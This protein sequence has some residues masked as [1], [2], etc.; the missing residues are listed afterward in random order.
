VN[1][2]GSTVALG[3]FTPDNG[4][5]HITYQSPDQSNL[6]AA[7]GRFLITEEPTVP[8]PGTPTA[9]QSKWRYYGELPQNPNP[10]APNNFSALDYL[11]DLLARGPISMQRN[12]GSLSGGLGFWFWQ[13]TQEV[14]ERAGTATGND[15]QKRVSA[16]RADAICILD[17]LDGKSLVRLDVPQGTPGVCTSA[18][19]LLTLNSNAVTPGFIHDIERGLLSFASSPGVTKAQQTLAGDIDTE[20]NQVDP[21]L[22]QVRN[23]AKQLVAM[24]N[25]DLRSSSSIPLLDDL[26]NQSMN[27]YVGQLDP[28]TGSRQGGA[29]SIFDHLQKLAQ[30]SVVAYTGQV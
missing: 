8:Q 29:I 13:K 21:I 16:M 27:A 2:N 4:S 24:S 1:P 17:L 10:N 14:F 18:K 9:D 11:R 25:Q 3:Q 12:A 26:A 20:L 30:F 19:P 23:D 6:L 5:T 15:S 22:E 28:T 7:A